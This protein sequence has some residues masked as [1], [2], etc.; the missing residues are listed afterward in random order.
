MADTKTRVKKDYIH[1]VGR[2]REAVARV[3]L[4]SGEVTWDGIE[5]RVGEV[6]VNRKPFDEYFKS[7]TAS[8]AYQ[9]IFKLTNTDKKYSFTIKV[10]GGGKVGQLQAVLHGMARALSELDTEKH[11]P[12]LKKN[13]YLTRDPRTRQRRKV[14]MGGKS[15]RKKQSPKR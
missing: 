15:R 1:S 14:G 10:A 4:H 7:E 12:V 6:F 5:V 9:E 8:R 13:G 11:R 3:R 2:R